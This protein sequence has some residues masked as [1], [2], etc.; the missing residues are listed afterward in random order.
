MRR[1]RSLNI[2]TIPMMKRVVLYTDGA[3]SG[4]PG[5]GGWGCFL[6]YKTV[7]KEA[8]GGR[9]DTTNNQMEL[10]A[11]IEGLRLL[12]QPCIVELYTDS[13][14]VLEGVT[15]WL[16]GWIQKGWRRAD[17]KPVANVELW[18][19]LLPLL[20]KHQIEWHW[21]KGHS[22]DQYNEYVDALAVCQRDKVSK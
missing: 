21:V 20:E 15:K 4:N 8:S 13:K 10:A 17:K 16:E 2:F 7:T 22:G 14:Y 1:K 6:M 5:P 3:C 12:K 11:V 9:P 19:E 18:K